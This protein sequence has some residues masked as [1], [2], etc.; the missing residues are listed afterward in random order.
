MN[1]IDSSLLFEDDPYAALYRREP[2]TGT[3]VLAIVFG[4]PETDGLAEVAEGLTRLL[5]RKGRKPRVEIVRVGDGQSLADVLGRLMAGGDEPLIL[6]STATR[7]WT[8][9]HLTPLLK[10]IDHA[11]H[12][13]GRRK[14]SMPGQCRRWFSTLAWRLVFAVPVR[15]VHS[16]CRLHR[17]EALAAIP[18]QSASSFLEI[19]ILAKATFFSQLIDEVDVP[20][21]E[22][23]R[24]CVKTSDVSNVF[25]HP[26]LK[27]AEPSVPAEDFQGDDERPDGPCHEDGQGGRDGD[28]A[29]AFE[30]HH[31][32]GG[33]DLGQGQRLDERLGDGR[34]PLG[35][36][37]DPREEPHRQHDQVHQPADRL[38]G[39]GPAG[40]Q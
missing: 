40:D 35:G 10:A 21:L 36:E 6:I 5:N 29:G 34:E 27:F 26:R 3:P 38:G 12:V 23:I 24:A 31:P 2:R 39:G 15:D 14:L 9:A 37:E 22:A 33:D 4:T 13:I 32:Q 25:R 18:L 30:D 8:E 11:D 17:R 16:P 20:P 1:P 7:P 19:E 28:E